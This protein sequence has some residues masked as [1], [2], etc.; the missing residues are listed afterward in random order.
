MRNQILT[1]ITNHFSTNQLIRKISLAFLLTG[2]SSPF[3]HAQCNAVP[4]EIKGTVYIDLNLNGISDAG[5]G[6]KSQAIIKVFTVNNQLVA[7]ATTDANG[8]FQVS[9]LTNLKTY[10]LELQKPSRL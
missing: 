3:I 4:G 7:Q 10:K 5:D 9:G 2:S 8:N 1:H 6:T